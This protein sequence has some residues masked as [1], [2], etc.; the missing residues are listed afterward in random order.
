MQNQPKT[1]GT[2]DYFSPE[3]SFRLYG[4]Q[5]SAAT[6]RR[7]EEK[8]GSGGSSV[9]HRSQPSVDALRASVLDAA[10]QLGFTANPTITNWLFNQ[11]TLEEEREEDADFEVRPVFTSLRSQLN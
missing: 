8:P 11:P 7:R 3:S 4:N 5:M 9:G 6:P 1:E 10:L 2:P